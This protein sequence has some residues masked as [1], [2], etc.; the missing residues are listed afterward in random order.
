MSALLLI[1][2]HVFTQQ[3]FIENIVTG[4]VSGAED[5]AVGRIDRICLVVFLHFHYNN[6]LNL[7]NNSC[8]GTIF[9]LVL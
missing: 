9:L 7:H 6:S 8:V 5:T 4:L 3:I 2:L 1:V